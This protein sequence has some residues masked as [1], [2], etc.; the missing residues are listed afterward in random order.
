M[1]LLWFFGGGSFSFFSSQARLEIFASQR[2]TRTHAF[3]LYAPLHNPATVPHVRRRARHSAHSTRQLNANERLG[4]SRIAGQPENLARPIPKP[5]VYSCHPPESRSTSH[6]SPCRGG[7]AGLHTP[8]R[9]RRLQSRP[10]SSTSR[11][12]QRHCPLPPWSCM[13]EGTIKRKNGQLNSALSSCHQGIEKS[14]AERDGNKHQ[15]GV[16]SHTFCA[17]A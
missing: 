5:L 9:T 14:K 7:L 4:V 16:A 17:G 15:N 1:T 11:P 6:V 2:P 12:H 3:V 10:R 8:R 13:M